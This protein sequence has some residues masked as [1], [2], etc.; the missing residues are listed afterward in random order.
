[1]RRIASKNEIIHALVL[2][3]LQDKDNQA[4]LQGNIQAQE[5]AAQ[6]AAPGM[7]F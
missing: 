5:Q 4:A 7:A 3:V 1:L 2:K 6:Q